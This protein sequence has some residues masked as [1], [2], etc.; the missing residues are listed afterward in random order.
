MTSSNYLSFLTLLSTEQRQHRV[1]KNK[2]K[3]FY[4]LYEE[5]VVAILSFIGGYVDAAGY[6]KFDGLFTSSI[7]GNLVAACASIY[8]TE[9]VVSRAIVCVT[10]GLGTFLAVS[11]AMRLKM[12]HE[13]KARSISS[14]L[15]FLEA[16][17]LLLT[18]IL[19]LAFDDRIHGNYGNKDGELATVSAI[20]GMAMGIHN[21]AAKDAIANCPSTTVMTMTIVQVSTN[22]AQTFMYRLARDGCTALFPTNKKPA[23]YEKNM[24]DK[25]VDMT[26]KLSVSSRPLIMFIAGALF[27]TVLASNTTYWCLLVPLG[28]CCGFVFDI[29]LGMKYDLPVD[30]SSKV[31]NTSSEVSSPLPAPS[32]PDDYVEMRNSSTPKNT[33]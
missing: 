6:V 28:F 23:E 18:M 15:F 8:H 25:C 17:A 16:L 29:Y 11:T 7:T 21:G 33:V 22:A 3:I 20:L 19:G 1:D 2:G 5:E 32:K 24:S 30:K 26:N 9:R 4:L 13:W 14:F 27:G 12:K 10:F 31:V